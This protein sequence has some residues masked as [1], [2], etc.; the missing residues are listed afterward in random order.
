M[1]RF[2]DSP[3][4]FPATIRHVSA[5]FHPDLWNSVAPD[6]AEAC[7]SAIEHSVP[8]RRSEYVAGRRCA[9]RAL[10]LSHLQAPLH[11]G[12]VGRRADR[13]PI[14]PAGRV[15]SITH[16]GSYAAAAVSGCDRVR[17][18]GIDSEILLG[19]E[20][21]ADLG[22]FMGS[23]EEIR[24]AATAFGCRRLGIT[25]LF[26]AKESLFKCLFPVVAVLFDF[27]DVQLIDADAAQGTVTLEVR[28]VLGPEFTPGWRAVGSVRL[29]LP[30]VHTG[31]LLPRAAGFSIEGAR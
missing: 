7:Q 1:F 19:R 20:H 23:D 5:T 9:V 10:E 29:D 30:Y 21:A 25:V 16:T 3:G 8:R 2:I 26:S 11:V 14:W 17:S 27:P 22:S 28:S 31:F 6:E 4:L 18:V 13:S 24:R 12:T 15:G